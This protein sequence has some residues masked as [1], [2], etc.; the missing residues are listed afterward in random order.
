MKPNIL[1]RYFVIAMVM[2]SWGCNRYL[3]SAHSGKR[4]VDEGYLEFFKDNNVLVY[5]SNLIVNRDQQKSYPKAFHTVLPKGIKFYVIDVPFDLVF[6]YPKKQAILITL[7]IDSE[8]PPK[9]T[10]YIPTGEQIDTF[11][12]KFHSLQNKRFDLKRIESKS[13]SNTI[14][15]KGFSTIL[16][17]NILDENDSKFT[18]Y[19]K[20]FTFL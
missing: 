5:K 2:F 3:D 10:A 12:T 6:Y 1:N 14:L 20:S 15:T 19:L 8:S 17:F 13:R 11:I 18:N 9:D 16:L 7:D 4:K